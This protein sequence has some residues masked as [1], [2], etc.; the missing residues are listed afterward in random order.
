MI[1]A[2]IFGISVSALAQVK[3]GVKAGA[4]VSYL[5]GIDYSDG[6]GATGSTLS[7][8]SLHLGG[9][10]NYFFNDLLGAQTEAVF[11]MQGGK[12]T[13]ANVTG[14]LYLNYINVPLLL[15][16]KPF[17]SPFSLFVGPQLGYCVGRSLLD[18][19]RPTI[20]KDHY[21]D[22]DFAIAWGMQFG[23]TEHLKLGFRHNIGLTPSLKYNNEY[24]F[25][26]T[27]YKRI[28]KGERNNV[29]HLSIGWT[30]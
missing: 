3:F 6:R 13:V 25:E 18:D 8:R 2:A 15:E 24:D 12:Y 20:N 14:T 29:L 26:G 11:S 30:F 10:A 9:Y 7:A 1:I 22:F 19:L 28:V 5:S 16:I 4:N 27:H 17:K 21:K 23:L